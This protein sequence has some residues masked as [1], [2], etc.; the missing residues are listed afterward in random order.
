V[1]TPPLLRVVDGM[2]VAGN[3]EVIVLVARDRVSHE[4]QV[5]TA[6]L[7]LNQVGGRVSG[8]VINAVPTKWSSFDYDY[9]VQSPQNV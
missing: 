4:H 7:R 3:A 5:Q 6:R 8:I 9:G 2:E 1:D